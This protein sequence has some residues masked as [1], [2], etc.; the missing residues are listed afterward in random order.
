MEDTKM[1]AVMD[2]ELF[3]APIV[4]EDAANQ[5]LF[6]ESYDRIQMFVNLDDGVRARS[7]IKPRSERK[8]AY[9]LM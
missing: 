4:S 8:L 3:A 7:T 1:V 6:K 5:K 2:S 9:T